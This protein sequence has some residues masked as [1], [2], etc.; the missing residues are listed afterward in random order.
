[1]KSF[2]RYCYIAAVALGLSS[3]G[4]FLKE[5]SQD[6]FEPETTDSYTELLN[7]EGY[8]FFQALDGLTWYMS[9]D[10]DG[11][12]DATNMLSFTDV[13]M[14]YQDV[15][16]WQSY[17]FQSLKDA[18][19][20]DR[21]YENYYEA[22]MVCNVIADNVMESDGSEA[23]KNRTL[24]EALTLRA[25]YYLQLVNIFATPYNDDRSAPD[26]RL[27]VP[28]VTKAE[29]RDEGT[30]AE[31][32]E[33]ITE[34]IERACELFDAN[35]QDLGVYRV[36]SVAAHLIA[37]RIYLYMEDWDKCI[38]HAT[39]ALAGAPGLCYLPDYT[40]DNSYAPI[41]ASNTVVSSTFPET[42]FLFGFR[43]S[44]QFMGSPINLSSDL[45][46]CFTDANDSRRG[47]YFAETP[48]YLNTYAYQYFKF[49][50]SEQTYVWRTAELYLNRA[51]AYA[52]KYR[53][54][55]NASGQLAVDDLNELR[56]NRITNYTDYTLGTADELVDFCRLERRRELFMEGHRWFDLR[57]Y[58]MPSIQ[59]TWVSVD[60]RRTTYTL[61][62]K[63]P[64]YV[65]PF[66]QDVL[67]RNPKLQQNELAADRVGQ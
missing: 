66:S 61:Q 46:N 44:D 54:G 48:A 6:E 42:I 12:P 4:D 19:T 31:V 21:T 59:H 11:N 60:G 58:G 29:I 28:L 3:C 16:A 37:S 45:V 25:Y 5:V 7:G 53:E 30:V 50:R 47:K 55:D 40:Y 1:M 51:E 49:G 17:M 2:K 18:S 65:V 33:Q 57:R 36:N 26:Q 10:V 13:Q 32:Y 9:D 8:V 52:E 67:D 24:A 35:P 64:G 41:N 63:D 22:I 23:D 38:E 39:T 34:D 27:G 14:A 15:F 43:L 20:E 62:E 56:R